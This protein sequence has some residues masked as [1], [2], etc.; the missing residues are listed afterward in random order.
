ML[1]NK[2]IIA[3]ENIEL[4]KNFEQDFLAYNEHTNLVS[5]NEINL[6]YE[7]HIYDSLSLD[8]FLDKYKL[9]GK[10]L[11]LLDIGTGGGFPSLPLA[12]CNKNLEI[13]AVDSISKKITFIN[14]IKEKYNLENLTAISE[15]IE[16]MEKQHFSSFDIVT[17]R[18]LASLNVILEYAMPFLKVG[19]YFVAYK[20]KLA[21]NEI[22]S[23]QNA[24]KILG[25]KIIEKID[26]ELPLTQAY[27]RNLLII[28]KEKRTPMQYPRNNG[29]IKKKPL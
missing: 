25:A 23:A 13:L 17:S 11:K 4:L 5:K 21:E 28:K 24:L 19:G 10:E 15:R 26:Y 1:K 16:N 7:K 29:L 14:Q 6:L 18:A 20:S 3:K 9:Q 2:I 12:F 8:L 27:E 22:L